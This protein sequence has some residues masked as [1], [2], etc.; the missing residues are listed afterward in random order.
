MKFIKF[1][2]RNKKELS[3]P[4][5][6]AE[7]ILNSDQQIIMVTQGGKW[8]GLTLNKAEII[9]TEP[10]LDAERDWRRDNTPQIA[11][12]QLTEVEEE[13]VNKLRE[14]INQIYGKF[15]V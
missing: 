5:E 7:Q 1:L 13:R 8:N 9:A 4:L 6:Q 14:E 15:K 10:D 3:L 12:P 11:E 2:L